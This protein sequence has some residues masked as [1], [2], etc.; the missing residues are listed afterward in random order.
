MKW[1]KLTWGLVVLAT[2]STLTPTLRGD[3]LAKQ[4]SKSQEQFIR[5]AAPVAG[6]VKQVH[7]KVGQRVKAETLLLVLDDTTA[8]HALAAAKL[9]LKLATHD[10]VMAKLVEREANKQ[11]FRAEKAQNTGGVSAEELS[12]RRVQALRCAEQTKKA[13]VAVK[14]KE[15]DVE[16]AQH[17]F[18][19]CRI[20]TPVAGIVRR[21][22]N[23]GEGVRYVEAVLVL[24]IAK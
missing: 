2:S 15:L 6:I 5:L 13:E 17:Q 7:I 3:E 21:H 19:R 16:K 18:S 1:R 4:F 20:K 9:Q 12:I 11:V 8:R 14:L 22:K 23:V 10:L 24:E